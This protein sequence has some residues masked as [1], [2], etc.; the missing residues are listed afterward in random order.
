MEACAC[1]VHGSPHIR[2]H[3]FC[4]GGWFMRMDTS[5]LKRAHSGFCLIA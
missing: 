3:G 1:L 2:I 4:S 5:R